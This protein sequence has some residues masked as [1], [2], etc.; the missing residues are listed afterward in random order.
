M[1]KLLFLSC[2]TLLGAVL[3]IGAMLWWYDREL[4]KMEGEVMSPLGK[5]GGRSRENRLGQGAE[6]RATPRERDGIDPVRDE[7]LV[8]GLDPIW[9]GMALFTITTAWLVGCVLAGIWLS[10]LLPA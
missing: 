5:S 6:R 8:S 4:T 7:L 2:I 10:R 1:T 3:F 9:K